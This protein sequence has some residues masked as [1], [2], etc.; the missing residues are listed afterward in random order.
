MSSFNIC[1]NCR[2]PLSRSPLSPENKK[3]PNCRLP[4]PEKSTLFKML[5]IKLYLILILLFFLLITFFGD[6]FMK[7]FK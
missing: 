5:L 1:P 3:C 4:F 7:I 6:I 2:S